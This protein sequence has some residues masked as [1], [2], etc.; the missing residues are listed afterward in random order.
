MTT[1]KPN[2][3]PMLPIYAERPT[4]EEWV[5]LLAFLAVRDALTELREYRAKNP[6]L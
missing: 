3:Q 5:Y 6:S 1:D 2:T 4:A